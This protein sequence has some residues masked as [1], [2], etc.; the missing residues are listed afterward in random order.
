[1]CSFVSQNKDLFN[2]LNEFINLVKNNDDAL[3]STLHHGQNI[4]GYLP[5][6]VQVYISE[7]LEIPLNKVE[8]TVN[9]YS[10]F[11]TEL[12]GKYK[13][14]V[15]LGNACSKNNSGQIMDEFKK[16]LNIKQGETTSDMKF[17]LEYS[18]CL[19][20]CRRPPVISINGRVYDDVSVGDIPTILKNC[21]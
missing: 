1:M 21:K 19:G 3:I 12:K 4:F 17:S 11:S 5:K 13:I 7:K 14:N 16:L 6:E 18:R 9:F 20:Y 8:N 10:Y 2:K 15:C